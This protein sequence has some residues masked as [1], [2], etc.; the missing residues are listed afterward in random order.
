M[1]IVATPYITHLLA[2]SVFGPS[3][4]VLALVLPSSD[5]HRSIHAHTVRRHL[6]P[7]AQ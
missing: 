1:T 6:L 5:L 4:Y 7:R 3:G 2:G